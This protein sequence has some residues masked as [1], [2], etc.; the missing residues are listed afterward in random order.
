MGLK[1]PLYI[2]IGHRI[3][4]DGWVDYEGLE[5]K[6]IVQPLLENTEPQ[7]NHIIIRSL[8]LKRN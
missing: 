3:R 5:H 6:Y 4:M 8:I 7:I 1:C 2:D